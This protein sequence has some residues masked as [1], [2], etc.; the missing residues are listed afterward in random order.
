MVSPLLSLFLQV[1]S[2]TG[3]DV[4]ELLVFDD[5]MTKYMVENAISGGVLA[6][7]KDGCVVY[8]RGFGTMSVGGG[9][10]DL[11]ENTPM[12]IA[13]LEKPMTAA[14]I[15]ALID[16]PAVDLE[17]DDH[18]FDVDQPGGGILDYEPFGG[19]LGQSPPGSTLGIADITVEHLLHH[20]AGWDNSPD[21]QGQALCIAEAMGVPTPPGRHR[22]VEYVLAQDLAAE[23]GTTYSYSNF[24]YM[25]LGLVVEAMA[26]DDHFD[27]LR[28]AVLTPEKWV[29]ST[30]LFLGRT[31]AA[32]QN[33]REP[34]YE[35]PGNGP[36]VFHQGNS[37]CT[38][39]TYPNACD[40]SSSCY[41]AA[42]CVPWPYGGWE[43]EALVGH[44]N[45][46]A[47]AAGLLV[48]ADE[49]VLVGPE[50][51]S[52]WDGGT[53]EFNGVLDGT[54]TAIRQRSDGIHIAVLFNKRCLAPHVSGCFTGN[55]GSGIPGC[56]DPCLE[57]AVCAVTPSCCS[58]EWDQACAD[59]A[60]VA[61]LFGQAD[62]NRC[63]TDAPCYYASEAISLVENLIDF[64]LVTS[65]PTDCVD[66]FWVD[67][68]AASPGGG[69]HDDPF[70]T[71]SG[72][73]AATT[74]GTKLRLKSGST[75]WTGVIEELTLL[76]APDGAVVIGA[77]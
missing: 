66:G 32:Y 41:P 7:M 63:N 42:S 64:G 20:R 28:Q 35:S 58:V 49:Y 51:G 29:P 72:A 75:S 67:F 70:S 40:S 3:A 57:Q 27:Y 22:T 76:D 39:P 4:D 45:A 33:P 15:R 12:R 62:C 10:G 47:S 24:G 43:Q 13:S 34:E 19:N 56:E 30:E 1:V 6:V 38:D 11:P 68:G 23:P 18:V 61:C 50:I 55:D 9:G 5:A 77:P 8:Q 21:P 25:V 44:G 14:A 69:S 16:D 59:Q 60:L 48:L 2:S 36:S 54:N 37:C 52:S 31:F 17:L 26:Q 65:W 71:M 53:R 74:D 73:L 46:V